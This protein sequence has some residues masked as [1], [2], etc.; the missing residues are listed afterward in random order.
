MRRD[1]CVEITHR[2]EHNSGRVFDERAGYPPRFH[3]AFAFPVPFSSERHSYSIRQDRR[4]IRRKGRGACSVD[5]VSDL[6]GA[7]D[8]SAEPDALFEASP[9]PDPEPAIRR[10]PTGSPGPNAPLAARMR[11]AYLTRSSVSSTCSNRARPAATRRRLRCSLRRPVRTS[12][13]RQDNPRVAHLW[14]HRPTLRSVVRVVRRREGRAC[15]HRPRASSAHPGRAD[16]VVHRRGP[17]L[18]QDPAGRAARGGREPD[19]AVGRGDDRESVVL[20]RRT[21]AVEVAGAATTAPRPGR[22]TCIARSSSHGSA[23][24][25]RDGRD[26]RGGARS[27]RETRRRRCPPRTDRTGGLV[28]N[29]SG[30]RR[31]HRAVIDLRTVE[32]SIDKAAVRYDR[33]GDQHYDVASAFIKSLRG[34]DVDA[35]LHYLARMIVAGED[36]RF[37]A[38]R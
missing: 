19:R 33:D 38:R 1:I 21:A 7:N 27:P 35:A 11:P 34:S 32:S 3:R 6:F 12:G 30:S 18:L 37:I 26:H 15:R 29:R 23:R 20:R 9:E 24:A 8:P 22:H 31:R 4:H 25:R 13:H 36:P 2:S 14:C 5:G 16:R 10:A 17:P 28:G